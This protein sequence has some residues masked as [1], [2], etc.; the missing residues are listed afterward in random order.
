M[1]CGILL[2]PILYNKTN[3]GSIVVRGYVFNNL[4]QSMK[5]MIYDFSRKRVALSVCFDESSYEL[6]D[7]ETSIR[8]CIFAFDHVE[9]LY[10]DN[11]NWNDVQWHVVFRWCSRLNNLKMVRFNNSNVPIDVLTCSLREMKLLH[12]EFMKCKIGHE[13]LP[14]LFGNLCD[15]LEEL[16]LTSCGV[17]S[18]DLANGALVISEANRRNL[19]TLS[20][21]GNG[22]TSGF[23]DVWLDSCLGMKKMVVSP[24]LSST[25]D[26]FL[27][28]SVFVHPTLEKII[29]GVCGWNFDQGEMGKFL[30]D[31]RRKAARGMM[32][33]LRGRFIVSKSSIRKLFPDADRLVWRLL[34]S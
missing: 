33:Y 13:H 24:G 25:I 14:K 3:T 7:V 22:L 21:T 34:R 6:R 1:S 19:N 4:F 8:F 12:V 2:Q 15:S 18:Q 29:F 5:E 30:G 26:D 28:P 27:R 9:S 31:E 17:S 11:V 23:V 10:F 32:A 20:V 16:E